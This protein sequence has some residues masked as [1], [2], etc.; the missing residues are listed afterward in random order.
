ME[1]LK[2]QLRLAVLGDPQRFRKILLTK[3]LLDALGLEHSDV[4]RLPPF[5]EALST[6]GNF[7]WIIYCIRSVVN[8]TLSVYFYFSSFKISEIPYFMRVFDLFPL[9]KTF[10][11]NCAID[12]FGK[13]CYTFGKSE[14]ST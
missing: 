9:Q 7:S 8:N 13:F 3:I 6:F 10:Q 5:P 12:T 14:D 1:Q 2:S 11:T 4:H